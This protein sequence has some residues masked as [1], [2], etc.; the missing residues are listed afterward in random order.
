MTESI[1]KIRAD[2]LQYLHNI[3]VLHKDLFGLQKVWSYTGY[4]SRRSSPQILTRERRGYSEYPHRS[5]AKIGVAAICHCN[6][7]NFCQRT[8][9]IFR[10][11]TSFVGLNLRQRTTWIVPGL[12]SLFF[13]DQKAPH[14]THGDCASFVRNLQESWLTIQSEVEF[15]RRV[16]SDRDY[17]NFE[18]G[19]HFRILE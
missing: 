10:I 11:S 6:L 12:L 4:D 16:P 13:E 19:R 7:Q 18:P 1:A 3:H 8:M 9:R 2:S 15:Q 5:L 14:L 17:L